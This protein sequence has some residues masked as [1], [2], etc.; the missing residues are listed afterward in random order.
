M[1]GDIFHSVFLDLLK[2]YDSLNRDQR[3]DIL[4]V[5][6]VSPKQY[7]PEDALGLDFDGGK[8]RLPLWACLPEPPRVNSRVPLS[9]TILTWL[10]TLA[11][12]TRCWY[13]PPPPP[14]VGRRIGGPRHEKT[15]HLS[16]FLC[17]LRLCHAA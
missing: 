5:Y 11:S 1:K 6:G 3:L 15:G 4:A 2:S 9:H 16:A 17:Q 14:A 7:V 10:L 13:Y 8:F 12:D